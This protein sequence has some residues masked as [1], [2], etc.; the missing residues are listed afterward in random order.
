MSF[1]PSPSKKPKTRS[2]SYQLQEDC[3]LSRAY[4]H[5]S[6][7]PV[8]GNGQKG[9]IFW[10]L[11][12]DEF[13]KKVFDEAYEDKNEMEKVVWLARTE[14]STSGIK[15][16]FTNQISPDVSKFL[17]ELK[18]TKSVEQSGWNENQYVEDAMDSFRIK[19]SKPFKFI[20]CVDILQQM[21]KFNA[22]EEDRDGSETKK[23]LIKLEVLWE[24]S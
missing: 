4:V 7:N 17:A 13:R 14:R 18:K 15:S 1:S 5:V 10:N 6:Q 12:L 22:F 20:H 16:R 24:I 19:Y 9:D 3:A 23:L 8:K 11:V 21:P 2:K